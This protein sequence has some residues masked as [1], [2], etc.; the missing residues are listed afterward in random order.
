MNRVK[1]DIV[2]AIEILCIINQNN[3]LYIFTIYFSLF[4]FRGIVFIYG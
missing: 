3:I 2:I 4:L 1:S